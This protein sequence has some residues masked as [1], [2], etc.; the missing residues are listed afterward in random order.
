MRTK[1]DKIIVLGKHT[2]PAREMNVEG[3]TAYVPRYINR[4]E[5]DNCTFG[6]QLRY[7]GSKLFSDGKYKG[8]PM[9][10]LEA[11]KEELKRRLDKASYLATDTWERSNKDLVLGLPGVR[12]RWM[13][14]GTADVRVLYL[15]VYKQ[16]NGKIKT[17][18][19]YIGTENTLDISVANEKLAEAAAYSELISDCLVHNKID[20]LKDKSWVNE[21]LDIHRQRVEVP[22]VTKKQ[23]MALL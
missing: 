5:S 13:Q 4:I 12:F 21:Q 2:I 18:S 8:N 23:I 16:F 11:A 3:K 1:V 20:K 7:N 6:W 14:V 9:A 15:N 10:S 17:K 19:F 22:T